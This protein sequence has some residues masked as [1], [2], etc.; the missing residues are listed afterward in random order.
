MIPGQMNGAS[1]VGCHSFSI[2]TWYERE[3]LPELIVEPAVK[4]VVE[5][6]S[7]RF[8]TRDGAVDALGA[9]ELSERG[10][11]VCLVGPAMRQEHDAQHHGG[12]GAGRQ[13]RCAGGWAEDHRNPG[14]PDD[15]ISG[16]RVVS[17]CRCWAMCS[18]D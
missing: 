10:R 7:K 14:R 4:L 12:S 3:P 5:G 17:C 11:G 16:A 1:Y 15:A 9:G 2:G 8:H 6:V 13:G 18:S